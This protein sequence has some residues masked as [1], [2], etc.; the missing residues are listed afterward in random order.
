[1]GKTTPPDAVLMSV[2]SAVAVGP[3]DAGWNVVGPPGREAALTLAPCS[4]VANVGEDD[5]SAEV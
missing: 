3:P 4:L 2:P 1:M 5:K